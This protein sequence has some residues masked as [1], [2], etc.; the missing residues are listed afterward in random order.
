[1]L[2]EPVD[3]HPLLDPTVWLELATLGVVWVCAAG[4]CA[5]ASLLAAARLGWL[6]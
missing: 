2:V 6:R 1:M 3:L 4:A 5:G